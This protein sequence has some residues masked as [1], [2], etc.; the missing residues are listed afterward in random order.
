MALT[1]GRRWLLKAPSPQDEQNRGRPQ[2]AK[3]RTK[4]ADPRPNG[5]GCRNPAVRASNIKSNIKRSGPSK[6]P[7][8]ASHSRRI[9]GSRP[10]GRR[11]TPRSQSQD[12][13]RSAITSVSSL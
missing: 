3:Q 1:V 13:I 12:G 11:R 8:H 7:H 4:L 9:P 2:E 6:G 10:T 5:G